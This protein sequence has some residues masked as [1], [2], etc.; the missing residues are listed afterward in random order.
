[1]VVAIIALVSTLLSVHLYQQMDSTML[2][3]AAH[4]L[5]RLAR[6]GRLLAGQYRRQCELNIDLDN[7][8]FWL[9]VQA[10]S[11]PVSNVSSGI[12]SDASPKSPPNTPQKAGIDLIP[13]QKPQK[14]ANNVTF[15]AARV[16]G[17]APV[18]SGKLAIRFFPDG[19]AQAALIRITSRGQRNCTLLINPWT[20]QCQIYNGIVKLPDYT[21]D[22][23]AG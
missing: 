8:T 3:G 23:D 12:S 9:S 6:Q 11:R 1:M 17:S 20:S 18:T 15:S 13:Y 16:Q 2:L 22:L 21:T 4:K 19:T 10:S 14:L 5:N 7:N